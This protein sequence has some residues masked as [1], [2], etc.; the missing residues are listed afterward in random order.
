MSVRVAKDQNP[1]LKGPVQERKFSQD[2]KLLQWQQ[3]AM[4]QELGT[5]ARQASMSRLKQL[6]DDKNARK[7][8]IKVSSKLSEDL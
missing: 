3:Q 6:M 1:F 4:L 8:Q 2:H 5:E 7:Q